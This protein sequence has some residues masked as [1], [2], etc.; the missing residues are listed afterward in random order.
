LLTEQKQAPENI[1]H[2]ALRCAV[3]N[4]TLAQHVTKRAREG[5]DQETIGQRESEL[6]KA[7]QRVHLLQ[8][9]LNHDEK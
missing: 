5:E 8:Q 2:D 6:Q 7:E 1:E 4:L 3:D 9:V